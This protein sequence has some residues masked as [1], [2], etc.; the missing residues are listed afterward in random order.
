MKQCPY[1]AEE[2]QEA[3]VVCKH[4]GRDL[5][6]GAP[7]TVTVVQERTWNPGVAAVLSFFIPGAGQIYKGQIGLGLVWLVVVIFGY[8]MMI[9]PG[10]ILHIICIVNAASGRPSVQSRAMGSPGDIVETRPAFDKNVWI[11]IGGLFL[12]VV[13]YSVFG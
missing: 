10:V 2:I 5:R 9:F 1:C 7:P 8:M 12:L 3:A 4:C 11:V 13:L 6:T